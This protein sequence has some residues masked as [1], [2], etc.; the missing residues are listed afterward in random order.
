[1]RFLFRVGRREVKCTRAEVV[2]LVAVE[3]GRAKSGIFM[4][5][6]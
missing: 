6:M 1:V 5:W 4:E 2:D 3:R